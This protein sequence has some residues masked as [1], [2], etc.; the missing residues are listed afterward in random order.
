[1]L[2][3]TCGN[4]VDFFGRAAINSNSRVEWSDVGWGGG[5]EWNFCYVSDSLPQILHPEVVHQLSFR[6]PYN[7]SFP[8]RMSGRRRK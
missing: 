8:V 5:W 1:M 4:K 3:A 7:H 2:H 6:I